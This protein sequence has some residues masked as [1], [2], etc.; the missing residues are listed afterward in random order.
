MTEVAF[1][2]EV[3][4]AHTTLETLPDT[5]QHPVCI[6]IVA[7][8]FFE[9][10]HESGEL[11]AAGYDMIDLVRINPIVPIDLFNRLYEQEHRR[12]GFSHLEFARRFCD[13]PIRTVAESLCYRKGDDLDDHSRRVLLAHVGTAT[14]SPS[15]FARPHK[16]VQS[17]GRYSDGREGRA[18]SYYWDSA[19]IVE[20]LDALAKVMT[21]RGRFAEALELNALA[22]G[23]VDNYRHEII[24]YHRAPRNA[25]APEYDGRSQPHKY[26]RMVRRDVRLEGPEAYRRH[27]PAMIL[28]Y[29]DI[30]EGADDESKLPM[31]P[32]ARYKSVVRM[33]DLSVG[34][35]FSAEGYTFPDGSPRPRPESRPVDIAIKEKKA[36]R[37]GRP[38]T[39][40]EEIE[41]NEELHTGAGAGTDYAG[42]MMGDGVNIETIR[43]TKRV[44]PF[45]MALVFELACEIAN[46]LRYI[47]DD[48]GA[49]S[50]ERVAYELAKTLNTFCYNE[51]LGYYVPFDIET[52]Q[53]LHPT[54]QDG[55]FPIEAG[56]TPD[57]R[58]RRIFRMWRK[59]FKAPGGLLT[60]LIPSELSWVYDKLWPVLEKSAAKA[61][62]LGRAYGL[63]RFI[64]RR[65]TRT[66]QI[67]RLAT[68]HTIERYD[69]FKLGQPG[70]G[71]EYHA[72][73][74]NFSWT[75]ANDAIL[76]HRSY[77]NEFERQQW[78][79]RR[80]I[81]QGI[82]VCTVGKVVY[83]PQ[84]DLKLLQAKTAATDK[85]I[86][87]IS[88]KINTKG[89]GNGAGVIPGTQT[90]EIK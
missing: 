88:A 60:S 1:R 28:E 16:L 68:G 57:N 30:M 74:H 15:T 46:G 37:L 32:G 14:N 82:G 78:E 58:M 12:P 75:E 81:A 51:K 79:R 21:E 20:G 17:G 18:V 89:V 27:L 71:G 36:Q 3:T 52:G 22:T 63:E 76:R 34:T 49:Q 69:A 48:L 31:V 65:M 80:K 7:R 53:F 29:L 84:I 2:P 59:H 50:F 70:G 90:Q 83:L 87:A 47:G 24:T 55:S 85:T 25:N 66:I 64:R 61:A 72:P 44:P 42:W 33:P 10:M 41:L 54:L 56:M 19:A 62:W 67:G 86:A 77:A 35:V 13:L 43:V 6:D 5:A 38:L 9:G 23:I 26:V 8:P 73:K 11:A 39:V 40:Q 45:K 4:E